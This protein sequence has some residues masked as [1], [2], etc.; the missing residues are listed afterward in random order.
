MHPEMVSMA[1]MQG[2]DPQE[3][4]ALMGR[5]LSY[6]HAA[7]PDPPVSVDGDLCILFDADGGGVDRLSLLPD[8]LL[9]NIIWRLPVKDAARTTVLSRRW[10]PIWQSAP[11]VLADCHLLSDGEDKIPNHVE[12]DESASVAAAVSRILAAHPGPIRCAH[13]ICCYMDE[14]RGQVALWLQHLAV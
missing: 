1:R 9:V 14:F 7:I 4:E 6:I 10:R 12:R 13:L 2:M 3:L 11:L 8:A 5:V